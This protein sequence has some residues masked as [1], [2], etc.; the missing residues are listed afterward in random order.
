MCTLVQRQSA[1]LLPAALHR[2]SPSLPTLCTSAPPTTRICG[3]SWCA[4]P[5]VLTL[6]T[7]A[8]LLLSFV[9]VALCPAR[10]LPLCL[11][12]VVG[13]KL[14][15]GTVWGLLAAVLDVGVALAVS[16][17]LPSAARLPATRQRGTLRP[18]PRACTAWAA[19][20]R[21][22][23]HAKLGQRGQPGLQHACPVLP[24]PPTSAFARETPCA[25]RRT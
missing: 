1:R 14:R 17:R 3:T 23:L 22:R 24:R 18:D 8:T 13:A 6:E 12:R 10:P 20:S 4:V 5:R 25:G 7:L 16:P 11:T 21:Q 9:F 15:D 2:R 19:L